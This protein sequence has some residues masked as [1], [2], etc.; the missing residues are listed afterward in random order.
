M[1]NHFTLVWPVRHENNYV[2]YC[3]CWISLQ[4]RQDGHYGVSI[5]SLT[6]LYSTVYSGADQ[7]KHQS[8]ASLVFLMEIH[9]WPVNSPH[10]VLVSRKM[11]AFDDVIMFQCNCL[12]CMVILPV[13]KKEI[14]FKSTYINVDP[15]SHYTWYC[16]QETIIT[17]V[18]L[19]SIFKCDIEWNL[20]FRGLEVVEL[21]WW[22]TV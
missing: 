21:E 2:F 11:L 8:S 14:T 13:T 16:L 7:K 10:K 6:I 5:T 22:F 12:P 15:T 3:W 20:C 17:F 18:K 1:E 19:F 4:W 9:W